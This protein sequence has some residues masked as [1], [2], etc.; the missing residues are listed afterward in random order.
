MLALVI[1]QTILSTSRRLALPTDVIIE[2][3]QF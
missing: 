2:K 3:K 1:M